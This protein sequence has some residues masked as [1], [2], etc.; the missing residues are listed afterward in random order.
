MR[1]NRG[2]FT[3]LEVMIVLSV[4]ALILAGLLIVVKGQQNQTEF[5]QGMH[6]IDL[7]LQ[8]ILN[9]VSTGNFTYNGKG[10]RANPPLYKPRITITHPNTDLG[11]RDE[12][13]FLG[14]AL[15][16]GSTGNTGST[17]NNSRFYTYTVLGRRT[18]PDALGNL[19]SVDSFHDANPT[20]M[21]SGGQ[22]LSNTFSFP[23]GIT[24]KS[25]QYAPN[26][27]SPVTSNYSMLGIYTSFKPAEVSVGATNP[28]TQNL[29]VY[30]YK[31]PD[32]TNF[33]STG[34]PPSSQY[35]IDTDQPSD[36]NCP[37]DNHLTSSGW[38][39]CFNSNS[40]GHTSQI[41]LL[42]TS[43]GVNTKLEFDAC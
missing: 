26:D 4:S 19:V 10:C 7:R 14:D 37:Y 5:Y 38:K 15:Q 24:L 25:I 11:T 27:G 23:D 35:C 1:H 40:S 41:T 12:C 28:A 8:D 31:L 29:Q 30:A 34:G 43:I 16:F 2:G 9:D 20:S 6:D 18:M 36:I 32:G 39:L 3:I 13:L 42:N 22:D 17:P 33:A 21:I